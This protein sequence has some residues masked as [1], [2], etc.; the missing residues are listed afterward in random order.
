LGKQ[1]AEEALKICGV[2]KREWLD[3]DKVDAEEDQRWLCWL[4]D[5][6]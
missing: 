2:P 1:L 3:P 4:S 6:P 5:S